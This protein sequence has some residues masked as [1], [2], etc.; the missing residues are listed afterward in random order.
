MLFKSGSM[1]EVLVLYYQKTPDKVVHS[2]VV[3]VAVANKPDEK[4]QAIFI[5][6]RNIVGSS[7]THPINLVEGHR[8]TSQNFS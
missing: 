2:Q 5:H 7:A 8:V 4:E 6:R 3:Q 1:I